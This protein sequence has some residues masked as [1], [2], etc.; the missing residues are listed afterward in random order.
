MRI[1]FDTNNFSWNSGLNRNELTPARRI[2]AGTYRIRKV[3]TIT[4]IDDWMHLPQPGWNT[5]TVPA[6]GVGVANFI[7]KY[8]TPLQPHELPGL[9]IRKVFHGLP[10]GMFPPGF[11]IIVVGPLPN[12]NTPVHPQTGEGALQGWTLNADNRYE[13][14]FTAAQ[15][16]SATGIVLLNITPG[17]YDVFETNYDGLDGFRFNRISFIERELTDGT[18]YNY[19]VSNTVPR[20]LHFVNVEAEDDYVIRIDNFYI[21]TPPAPSHPGADGLPEII[22]P[23]PATPQTGVERNLILPIIAITLG[24]GAIV[25]AGFYVRLSKNSKKTDF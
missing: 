19:N 8:V 6:S 3:P 22:P 18:I 5:V 23:A 12:G 2:A 17:R 24:V 9:R 20:P 10:V 11:E 13:I 21:T 1:P 4:D 7:N 14:R 25:A 15:S 16:T